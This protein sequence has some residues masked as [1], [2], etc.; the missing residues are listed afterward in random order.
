MFSLPDPTSSGT[1]N[2]GVG[3]C[4]SRKTDALQARC[5]FGHFAIGIKDLSVDLVTSLIFID[6]DTMQKVNIPKT[7]LHASGT[8]LRWQNLIPPMRVDHGQR[9]L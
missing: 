7:N 2:F 6:I 8:E 5:R 3:S 1:R 4:V 9:C